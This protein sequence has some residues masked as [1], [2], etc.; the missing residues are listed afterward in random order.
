MANG[1]KLRRPRRSNKSGGVSSGRSG[2]LAPGPT[3]P[4]SG[5]SR[6]AN[7]RRSYERYLSL[8]QAAMSAGDAVEIENHY[9]HA[10]H[11]LRQM[12]EMAG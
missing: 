2:G 10:E 3:N 4:K 11:Y 12:K 5:S 9:Q 1:A 6:I 8:A 7:L